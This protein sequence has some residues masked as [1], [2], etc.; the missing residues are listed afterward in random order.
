[1]ARGGARKGAGRP[2]GSGLGKPARKTSERI[3]ITQEAIGQ[4]MTPLEYMLTVMRTSNDAKRKDTM[5]IAAA[6]YI[7]P[8]LA[9]TNVRVDDNRAT[10]ELTTAELIAQIEADRASRGTAEE[11]AGER[12]PDQI[13]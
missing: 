1:M 7:H 2:I 8:R 4:G 9:S 10:S 12:E 5:A 6:P 11:E 13:H 3:K